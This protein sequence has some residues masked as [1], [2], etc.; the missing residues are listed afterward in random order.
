MDV[1]LLL[2]MSIDGGNI[3]MIKNPDTVEE[4]PSIVIK[5]IPSLSDKEQFVF[6]PGVYGKLSH[7]KRLIGGDWMLSFDIE[8]D[9]KSSKV[10]TEMITDWFY[11]WLMHRVIEYAD[12]EITWQGVIWE[13]EITRDGVT[14]R[15][16]LD[17]VYTAVKSIY[18]PVDEVTWLETSWYVS[19]GGELKYGRREYLIYLKDA[20]QTYAE[21]QAQT[22][23]TTTASAPVQLIGVDEDAPDSLTITCVGD[24]FTLNNR[25]TDATLIGTDT[26]SNLVI[27]TLT[28]VD[29]VTQGM[30]ETNNISIERE[31]M[32]PVRAGDYLTRLAAIG[33]TVD[34]V[35][36]PWRV[37]CKEG[38]LNY[39][40][41]GV[42]P[43]FEWRGKHN[44]FTQLMGRSLTWGLEPG[45][46]RDYTELGGDN[47]PENFL[48][49]YR[50]TVAEEVRMSLGASFPTLSHA[51]FN[52][53]IMRAAL[54]DFERW[55]TDYD[56]DRLH[57][58]VGETPPPHPD[59]LRPGRHPRKD[60]YV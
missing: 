21:Q 44:G 58:P 52:E 29:F 18:L 34:G 36:Q 20:D 19:T 30:I 5:D 54:A 25:Y 15:R 39:G 28:D 24:W 22:T 14:K 43:T 48:T 46:M 13:L 16:T 33:G 38:R 35:R 57:T 3:S 7:H 12:G 60:I 45:I 8:I 37:Y 27:D 1:L 2:H 31:M 42:E 4:D 55:T 49:D 32:E 40:P 9:P 53:S 10:T 41:V 59:P 6:S 23:L 26:I 56:Y 47:T 17:D 11:D 51:G 50:D